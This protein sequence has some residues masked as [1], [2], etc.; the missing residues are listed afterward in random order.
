MGSNFNGYSVY[1]D[2]NDNYPG[3][4]E[5][6]SVPYQNGFLEPDV[7]TDDHVFEDDADAAAPEVTIAS[8]FGPSSIREFTFFNYEDIFGPIDFCRK[9]K[10]PVLSPTNSSGSRS[11]GNSP[12]SAAGSPGSGSA[13]ARGKALSPE[14]ELMSPY[15]Y[16]GA[17]TPTHRAR[18]RHKCKFSPEAFS[19]AH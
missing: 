19:D 14:D 11:S 4:G 2:E 3:R 6:R 17:P 12:G 8:P 13:G 7:D 15:L 18:K 5:L 1:K 16:G 9:S 10:I